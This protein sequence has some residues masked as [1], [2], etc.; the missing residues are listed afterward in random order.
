M[1]P[2]YLGITGYLVGY[3]WQQRLELQEQ[4]RQLEGA[5][6]RHRI[7]RELHDG[8]AQ[9]LGGI[10]LRLEDRAGGSCE[11]ET[12]G[13]S[14]DRPH[15]T[16][17]R[18]CSASTTISARYDDRW[19]AWRPTPAPATTT[20]R[21][22]CGI[23]ATEIAASLALI[24]HVFGIPREGARNLR[25]HARARKR[26]RSRCAAPARE[27]RIDIERRRR[28]VPDRTSPW[29][30][31]SRVREAGGRIASATR[32]RTSRSPCRARSPW[33]ARRA[34]LPRPLTQRRPARKR[35]CGRAPNRPPPVPDGPGTDQTT[36]R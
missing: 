21:R 12:K 30:I 11:R 10:N 34:S 9:A 24:E 7:A 13:R 17:R 5:E 29:S 4:M 28:R 23:S 6:Q 8:Y 26:S 25:R 31:A 32:A 15:R 1:R 19:P 35:D 18:A 33:R 22:G 36:M 27:V 20:G 2:V 14:D 3:L 16:C